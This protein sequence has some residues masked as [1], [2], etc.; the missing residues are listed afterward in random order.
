[1]RAT[2]TF[3]GIVMAMGI[4]ALVVPSSSAVAAE[5]PPNVGFGAWD[6]STLSDVYRDVLANY[7]PATTSAF[8]SEQARLGT[9]ATL[10][11]ELG[12]LTV[13][14]QSAALSDAA[15]AART[16]SPLQSRYGQVGK[17]DNVA[18]AASAGA[19]NVPVMGSAINSKHSWQRVTTYN[20]EDC[21][22]GCK[23]TST[24]TFR[25][26]TDPGNTGSKTS[27]NFLKTGTRIGNVTLLSN[28]YSSGSLFSSVTNNW[29]TPGTGVQW[30][31]PHAA[32][33]GRTFQAYYKTQI[34]NPNGVA[35]DQYKT[36]VATCSQ[37]SLP[38]CLWP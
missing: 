24:L 27:L 33:A 3:T 32:T 26:T 2:R 29:S 36:Q 17:P 31:T 34:G 25:Y 16:G 38:T 11:P 15:S 8:F 22:P 21:N 28:I 14:E 5:T 12:E 9:A 18:A 10:I 19:P 13:A 20:W 7:G 23:I 1:M 30:N 6:Y 35:T 37:G 4:L